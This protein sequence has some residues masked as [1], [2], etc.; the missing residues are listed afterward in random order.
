MES[1]RDAVDRMHES[2]RQQSSECGEV[3][4]ALEQIFERTRSNEEATRLSGVRS[5]RCR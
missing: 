1:V 5:M 2:L 3:A 4:S